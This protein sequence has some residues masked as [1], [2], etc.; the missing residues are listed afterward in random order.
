MSMQTVATPALNA[1]PGGGQRAGA[2]T[3]SGEA[4]RLRHF[5]D[6]ETAQPRD[7]RAAWPC[8]LCVWR[9]GPDGRQAGALAGNRAHHVRLAAEGGQL[10]PQ[11]PRLLERT[12]PGTVL[13][14]QF[15]S[16]RLPN[17]PRPTCGG[18]QNSAAKAML[19]RGITRHIVLQTLK[20][21]YSRWP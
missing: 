14:R 15:G 12:R 21:G 17:M 2:C 4:I 20:A 18:F 11:A 13:K 3:F 5:R 19:E 7:C 8:R 10:Q 1:K 9:T 16:L 6:A